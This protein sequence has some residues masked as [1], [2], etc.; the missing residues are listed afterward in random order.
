MQPTQYAA[1]GRRYVALDEFVGKTELPVAF[2]IPGLEEKTAV[3]IEH[4]RFNDYTPTKIG[5]DDL[6]FTTPRLAS[7]SRYWP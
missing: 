6:H 2:G 1:C 4:R 7:E 5:F 3:V